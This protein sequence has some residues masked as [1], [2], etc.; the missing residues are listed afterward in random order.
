MMVSGVRSKVAVAAGIAFIVVGGLFSK[1]VM[2]EAAMGRAPPDSATSGISIRAIENFKNYPAFAGLTGAARETMI[3]ITAKQD[4]V[5]LIA[6]N[7]KAAAREEDVAPVKEEKKAPAE[8]APKPDEKEKKSGGENLKPSQEPSPS[9]VPQL[10]EKQAKTNDIDQLGYDIQNM[11]LKDS[12]GTVQLRTR[13]NEMI[14]D[15]AIAEFGLVPVLNIVIGTWNSITGESILPVGQKKDELP[16][17][18]QKKNADTTGSEKSNIGTDVEPASGA[19]DS[20]STK[21]IAPSENKMTGI[22]Q[23]FT[24]ISNEYNARIGST[25]TLDSAS[26]MKFAGRIA[27]NDS[28]YASQL[29]QGSDEYGM[30]ASAVNMLLSIAPY[31]YGKYN[32]VLAKYASPL[33]RPKKIAARAVE[34]GVMNI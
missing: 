33:M 3:R 32:R 27:Y 2:A 9:N 1:P 13:L 26:A 15:T 7:A 25:G 10:G 20:D 18:V 14:N 4:G 19:S 17:G 8:E 6:S 29:V 16:T 5:P 34:T 31:D 28:T 24:D 11:N 30:M 23:L 22:E 21:K 12:A